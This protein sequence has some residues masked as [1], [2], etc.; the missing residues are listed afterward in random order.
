[1]R[2]AATDWTLVA[3]VQAGEASAFD[4]IMTRYKRPILNFVRR[5]LNDATEAEDVAQD[6][7]V[8]A[9]TSMCKPGF[10]PT[11]AQS[12]NA[13]AQRQDGAGAT[14]AWPLVLAFK[15]SSISQAATWGGDAQRVGSL[16]HGSA[17]PRFNVLPARTAGAKGGEHPWHRRRRS[18]LATRRA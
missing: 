16:T 3:Q 18:P 11:A 13:G 17:W 1:M 8:R 12:V 10:R 4:A 9:Y 2:D 14:L 7:F 15:H 6:V 5:L